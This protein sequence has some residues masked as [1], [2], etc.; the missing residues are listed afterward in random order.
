MSVET[1]VHSIW[2]W[3]LLAVLWTW[4]GASVHGVPH[5][6]IRRA[7]LHGGPDAALFDALARRSLAWIDFRFHREGL[8]WGLTGGFALSSLTVLALGFGY[9]P[10]LGLWAVAAPWSAL[11]V[12]AL[13]EAL[14]L[15]RA[16][17]A[18]DELLRRFVRRR[19]I[20]VG[21]GY[22]A[23]MLTAAVFALERA[24]ALAFPMR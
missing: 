14:A 10:A 23:V 2:Y 22:A 18:P 6:A 4:A 7:A 13:R 11:S 5:H 19:R 9:E 21:V 24:G 1:T 8:W 15:H 20:H 3:A 12:L 16:Q 17:P